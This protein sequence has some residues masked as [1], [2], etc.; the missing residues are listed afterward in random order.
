MTDIDRRLEAHFRGGFECSQKLHMRVTTC[1]VRP[2]PGV[3]LHC[4]EFGQ[5]DPPFGPRMLSA[6]PGGFHYV[7]NTP[8]CRRLKV[9]VDVSGSIT[10][11]GKNA[12]WGWP[13]EGC[14]VNRGNRRQVN[15]YFASSRV[16]LRPQG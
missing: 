9:R 7:P 2:R 13:P 6:T 1:L 12:I 3:N 14:A 8:S 10:L 15:Y 16:P 11:P 4:R 5:F